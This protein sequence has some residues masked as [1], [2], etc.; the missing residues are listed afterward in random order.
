M[1]SCARACRRAQTRPSGSVSDAANPVTRDAP[2]ETVVRR[3]LKPILTRRE[4]GEEETGKAEEAAGGRRP[5][6]GRMHASGLWRW[7]TWRRPR[8][9]WWWSETKVEQRQ[10][11][12]AALRSW[13]SEPPTLIRL[14]LTSRPP[15]AEDG[16]QPVCA[17]PQVLLFAPRLRNL[18]T[19]QLLPTCH[20][21]CTGAANRTL[22]ALHRK[23]RDSVRIQSLLSL[24]ALGEP[25][26]LTTCLRDDTHKIVF[27]SQLSRP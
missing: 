11:A 14:D 16:S 22:A 23:R 1:K 19:L 6:Y 20:L 8:R 13:S 5:W 2:P 25:P 3:V 17:V 9:R 18:H 27:F 12:V 4:G 24:T 21:H 10:I 7:W 15:A 26:S